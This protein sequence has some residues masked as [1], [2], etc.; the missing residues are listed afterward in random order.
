[1]VLGVGVLECFQ[2]V[3]CSATKLL[4]KH[5]EKRTGLHWFISP[6]VSVHSWQLPR[7][8]DGGE[9]NHYDS[10]N[11]QLGDVCLKVLGRDRKTEKKK[12]KKDAEEEARAS[13]SM[14]PVINFSQAGPIL[15]L[16]K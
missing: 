1:M 4:G 8:Q 10:R 12:V 9:A 3:F 16:K 2:Q 11:T 6:V 5:L 15:K 7:L 13:K 14:P